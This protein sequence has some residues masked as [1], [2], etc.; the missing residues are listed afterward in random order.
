ML[1]RLKDTDIFNAVNAVYRNVGK[2]TMQKQ[3]KKKKKKKHLGEKVGSI[4]N[5]CHIF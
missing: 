1:A 4:R 3:K 5:E 2:R